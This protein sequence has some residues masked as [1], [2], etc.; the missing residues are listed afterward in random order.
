M[1]HVL[2]A[3]VCKVENKEREE[4]AI[5]K[6]E[7]ER[8]RESE[9]SV[10]SSAP[11]RGVNYVLAANYVYSNYNAEDNAIRNRAVSMYLRLEN[12]KG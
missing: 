5:F 11:F 10:S 4:G 6:R 1:R 2:G 7:R 3:L 8:E 12:N 9:R